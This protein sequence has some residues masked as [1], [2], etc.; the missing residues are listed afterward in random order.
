MAPLPPGD[1]SS[2]KPPRNMDP[3]IYARLKAEAASPYRGLRRFVY[4]ACAGSGVIGGV[5]FLA[6]LAAG[7]DMSENL[8]NLAVQAGV[9]AL[10][11]WLLRLENK[12]ERKQEEQMN[13]DKRK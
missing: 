2:A 4:L 6:K 1:R 5:V 13:A 10:M 3:E 9:V 8:P 11:V 7:Q 12:A